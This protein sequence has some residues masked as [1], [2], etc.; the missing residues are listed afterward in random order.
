[1]FCSLDDFSAIAITCQRSK[2]GKLLPDALYVH[3]SALESLDP[4]LQE[5][6]S[7]A[8][9]I[10]ARPEGITLVKFN[11][12]KPSISY[13]S[14]P[15]FDSDPHPALQS[16]IQVNLQSREVN[17]RDYGEAGNPF[18]LHRKETFVTTDYPH[19]QQFAALTRQEEALGLL[20]NPKAI[21]TRLAW[22]ERLAQFKVAFQGHTLVHRSLLNSRSSQVKIDRHKAA[23][24]RNDFSKPVRLALEA[25]LLNQTTTF[26]D[27]GC[28]QGG[29][30]ERVGKLGYK[31]AGWDPYY[32]PDSPLVAAD[33]VNLGY[34]INVIESQ[35]ERREA[36]IKAWELTRQVLIVAAQ[37]LI[38]QGNSQI[39]YG[40]GVI[41][42]RNTFQKYYDQ[43]ELKIYID[44][45]LG[46]DA[47]PAALGIYFV[48]RDESQAQTF[49]ASRFRSRVSVPKVQLAN[50]RFEDYK[51]LLTP[52]MAFFTERGRL[53]T[54]EELPET[55][56][57]NTEFGNLRRAFQIVLQ[58]TN[59]Q[60]WDEISD[61]RRQ[62]LLVYLALS[63][64]GRRPKLRDLTPVVQNDIKSLFG[65]Y[66]QA[67]AAADLMLMSLGNLEVI[68][69]RCKSS[70]IGQRRPNSL[71]VHVSAIEAL[72]PLLR[73]YEGCASRT[74][75]RPQEANVVKFHFRKPK[76]SYLFYP[77]FDTDPHPALHTSMEIDLRDLRVHYQDYDPNDNPPLLHQ[78]DS[79][80]TADYP[81]Y[82]KFAKLTRQEEGWGLLDDL[83][84]IYDTRGWQKCLEEHCAELKGHRVVWRK[85]ADPYRVKLVRS[86]I[87]AKQTGRKNEEE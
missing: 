12:E 79:I 11:L 20:D 7:A 73:L 52:L 70:A 3:V 27:Y 60:E 86:A 34:V 16:S 77:N 1:M 41:T 82:E 46:V 40:D 61:R 14:Y 43:E 9:E 54:L 81:L 15:E 29:D 83:R 10:A 84:L 48:F 49:R 17:Y 45:V 76:I 59:P 87:Q 33:V 4:L 28:G 13:L 75:G 5:Y 62:D 80:V 25:G 32:R 50:K 68:E 42:S 23:I 37:V 18:I 67:C 58:A 2:V 78:K 6:E 65:G 36:L 24:S 22:E 57:L 63:H 31:S 64:F 44:Q 38:A 47:V 51:E 19:Y 56:A 53:P 66:Q 8:R 72:D 69:K 39:A 30:L 55:E 26:F 21:G 85:D 74:I 71:W 35:A